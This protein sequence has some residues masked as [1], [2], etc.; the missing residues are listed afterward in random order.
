[1]FHRKKR[2]Y[3]VEE[4][5]GTWKYVIGYEISNDGIMIKNLHLRDEFLDAEGVVLEKIESLLTFLGRPKFLS[6]E[7]RLFTIRQYTSKPEQS[8][9]VS[10]LKL[11]QLLY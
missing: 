6:N 2:L 11:E 5:Q 3:K 7:V 10:V 9:K 8:I 4:K 1:V